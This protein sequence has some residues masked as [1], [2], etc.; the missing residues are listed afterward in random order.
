MC[1]DSQDGRIGSVEVDTYSEYGSEIIRTVSLQPLSDLGNA[2][3]VPMLEATFE[4]GVGD[5]E[6]KN[7]QIRLETSKDGKSFNDELS[8]NLGGVGEFNKRQIW[9]R[10]G[11]FPRMSIFKFT[12]SDP[13][14]PVFIKLEANI[15]TSNRGR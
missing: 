2:I 9:Y 7:P 6:I 5:L 14:K 15:R 11:R 4:S 1:G 12:M 3:S 10:L 8:R 13:V